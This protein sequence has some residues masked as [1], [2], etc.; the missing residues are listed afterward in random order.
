M[1]PVFKFWFNVLAVRL[2]SSFKSELADKKWWL[3]RLKSDQ[4]RKRLHAFLTKSRSLMN[5]FSEYAPHVPTRIIAWT[6]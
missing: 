3:F 4:K 1:F 5:N 6:L 2:I